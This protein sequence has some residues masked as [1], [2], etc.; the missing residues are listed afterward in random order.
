[1]P[2]YEVRLVGKAATFGEVPAV[3]VGKL[4]V[5]VQSAVARA[6]GAAI[7]RNVKTRG[8]WE[9]VI[10]DATRLRLV[11]LARGSIVAELDISGVTPSNP[12]FDLRV[13]TLGDVGWRATNS[14][15]TDPTAAD[16]GVVVRL[17]QL[18]DELGIGDRYD[19]V[20]FGSLGAPAP[21]RVKI[22]GAK[23]EQLA[24][25]VRSR[26]DQP[27]PPAVIA[28]LLFEADFERR[29]ARV[30]T[31]TGEPVEVVFDE[32]LA[33]EIYEALRQRSQFEGEVTFDPVTNSIKSVKLR[34]VTRT[35]QLLLGDEATAFWHDR[36]AEELIAEQR[37]QPLRSFAELRDESLSDEEFEAFLAALD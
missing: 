33:D 7:G 2:R 20:Q 25:V 29:T 36:T 13:D 11:R 15:I 18:A 21:E 14:A 22:D 27:S 12:E 28:G 17:S 34:R 5:G 32:E 4:L 10:E 6:A 31:V 26:R 30:R 37:K 1:M 16:L 8:R 3:D 35:E 24:A 23:R 9:R 19:A